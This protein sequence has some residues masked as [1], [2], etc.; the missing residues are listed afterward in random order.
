MRTH[1]AAQCYLRTALNKIVAQV[2]CSLPAAQG[3]SV[4]TGSEHQATSSSKDIISFTT[5]SSPPTLH[6]KVAAWHS[7]GIFCLSLTCA[8]GPRSDEKEK[9]RKNTLNGQH[10]L[11]E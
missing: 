1:A 11:A 10:Q 7:S 3:P 5:R 9:K 2:P 6:W 4:L 8:N